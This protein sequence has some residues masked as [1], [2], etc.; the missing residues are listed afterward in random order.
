MRIV[1]HPKYEFLRTW[2]EQLPATFEQQGEVIYEERNQIRR[3]V[4]EGV[5]VVA[6]RFH[7][8][9][10]I[11]RIAYTLFRKPKAVRAYEN[12]AELTERGFATPEPIAYIL[13][14]N[15][16][17]KESYLVTLQSDLTHTF[18]DFRDGKIAGKEDLIEAFALYAASLH[19]KGVLHKDFS[20]G[21]IRWWTSTEC[22]SGLFHRKKGVTIFA[23][24][25]ERV[26]S[27]KHCVLYMPR[28]EASMRGSA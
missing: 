28:Q 14:G 15:G 11:N 4:A 10:L 13:C 18:Y 23:G 8:P 9:S 22:G 25:G 2:L 12:A 5:A 19:N 20:P 7:T 16:L 6:K 1:I 27:L 26:I 17:L 24:C 3:I 21:N